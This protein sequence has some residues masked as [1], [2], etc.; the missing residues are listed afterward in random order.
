[1]GSSI[2]F[3]TA[4]QQ[5]LNPIKAVC[6]PEQP[7]G[8]LNITDSA[9]NQLGQPA[10]MSQVTE[11]QCEL[12]QNGLSEEPGSIPGSAS[13]FRVRIPGTHALRLIF[14]AGRGFDGVLYDL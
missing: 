5:G 14:Q 10:S 3:G 7:D 11:S 4:S 6:D 8:W 13:R 12:D 9:F 1:M 2:S